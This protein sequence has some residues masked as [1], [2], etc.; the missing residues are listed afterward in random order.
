[1]W[2]GYVIRHRCGTNHTTQCKIING[3]QVQLLGEEDTSDF[4]K[5]TSPSN[6]LIATITCVQQTCKEKDL[7]TIKKFNTQQKEVQ[8]LTKKYTPP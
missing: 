5:D 7:V 1:M 4:D 3:K 6:V 8:P 2:E